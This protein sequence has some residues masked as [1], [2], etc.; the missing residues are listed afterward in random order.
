MGKNCCGPKENRNP[1]T[2]VGAAVADL[3]S[4]HLGSVDDPLAAFADSFNQSPL[5]SDAHRGAFVAGHPPGCAC[6]SCR[7]TEIDGTIEDA[8]AEAFAKEASQKSPSTIIGHPPG[9]ACKD[10]KGNEPLL[11]LKDLSSLHTDSEFTKTLIEGAIIGHPPGCACKNC[12][13]SEEAPTLELADLVPT[14]LEAQTVDTFIGHP[15]GCACKNCK[16]E[17]VPSDEV[18]LEAVEKPDAFASPEKSLRDEAASTFEPKERAV[19]DGGLERALAEKGELQRHA[20]EQ[21]FS[22]F[23]SDPVRSDPV[24]SAPVHS[25]PVHSAPAP[26]LQDV[27]PLESEGKVAPQEPVMN[28]P[29]LMEKQPTLEQQVVEARRASYLQEPQSPQV[30]DNRI[31]PAELLTAPISTAPHFTAPQFTAP[32]FTAPKFTGPIPNEDQKFAPTT[33]IRGADIT[34]SRENPSAEALRRTSQRT[35]PQIEAERGE[36]LRGVRVA[37]ERLTRREKPQFESMIPNR[38]ARLG[39]VRS[40]SLSNSGAQKPELAAKLTP[41]GAPERGT[42]VPQRPVPERS[43]TLATREQRFTAGARREATQSRNTNEVSVNTSQRRRDSL[44]AESAQRQLRK[45]I[46]SSKTSISANQRRANVALPRNLLGKEIPRAPIVARL[47]ERKSRE[48]PDTL[49]QRRL[50]RSQGL[51]VSTRSR[52]SA[53]RVSAKANLSVLRQ[54][55]EKRLSRALRSEE[56]GIPRETSRSLNLSKRGE[57]ES[58]RPVVGQQLKNMEGIPLSRD[59]RPNQASLL[60]ARVRSTRDTEYRRNLSHTLAQ[61]RAMKLLRRELAKMRGT[62]FELEK[63]LSSLEMSIDLEGE[64]LTSVSPQ[65]SSQ[66][67]GFGVTERRVRVT[68]RHGREIRRSE[69]NRKKGLKKSGQ[70]RET[71]SETKP[72]IREQAPKSPVAAALSHKG[73]SDELDLDLLRVEDAAPPGDEEEKKQVH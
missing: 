63:R 1:T 55:I 48:S 34:L 54:S 68:R 10:C 14:A 39:T 7:D 73:P 20:S 67:E 61:L 11:E 60:S 3:S 36:R 66:S 18:S 51:E 33:S 43:R 40:S 38:D 31:Q 37:L 21:D 49:N 62:Y 44:Q 42:A 13:G 72:P 19:S 2:S 12:K 46:N 8:F 45:R 5:P 26:M 9:C 30:S 59:T 27:R 6:K 41:T 16:G 25:D 47:S 50:H 32:Q 71:S 4:L 17:E 70:G 29:R 64:E 22:P 57:A 23:H 28:D 35:A 58:A 24:R 15:P 69:S 52:D 56:K 53:V 65:D